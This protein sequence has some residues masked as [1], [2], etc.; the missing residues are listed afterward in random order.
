MVYNYATIEWLADRVNR[1]GRP[2]IW[3]LIWAVAWGVEQAGDDCHSGTL[4]ST[5]RSLSRAA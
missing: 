5:R 1:L 4:T 3:P 2:Q